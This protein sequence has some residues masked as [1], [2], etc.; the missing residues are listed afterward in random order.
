MER[1]QIY[2]DA[3]LNRKLD[4]LAYR[5]KAS[6]ASLIRDGVRLLLRERAP[7]KDEPLMGLRRAAAR[8]G[9]KDLSEGHDAFLSARRKA[10]GT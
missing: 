7:L 4:E 2:L 5:I 1:F 9:R 6:K 3:E 10:R 8:S